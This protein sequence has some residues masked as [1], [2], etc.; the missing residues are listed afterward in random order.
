[1][2]DIFQVDGRAHVIPAAVDPLAPTS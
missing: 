2:P 1:M